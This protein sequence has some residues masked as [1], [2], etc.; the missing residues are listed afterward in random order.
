MFAVL[1]T[2][3]LLSAL[4]QSHLE[5]VVNTAVSWGYGCRWQA[6][7]RGEAAEHLP[8]VQPAIA[9]DDPGIH[10]GV[11]IVSRDHMC[12]LDSLEGNQDTGAEM[13]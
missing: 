12:H 13:A 4:I 1:L 9:V 8:E 2:S 10:Q 3:V 7:G 6:P 5:R 11:L